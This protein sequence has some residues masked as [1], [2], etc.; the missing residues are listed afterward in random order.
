M[1]LIKLSEKIRD[2]YQNDVS[3]IDIWDATLRQFHTS[4]D[5]TEDLSEI[6]ECIFSD[7]N[8][9]LSVN[10]R[11]ALLA[12]AKTLGAHSDAF[13]RDYFGFFGAHLDPSPEKDAAKHSLELLMPD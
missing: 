13:L 4:L 8:W 5:E 3:N 7:P 10:E 12:K 6:L 9:E 11:F 2:F 1:K